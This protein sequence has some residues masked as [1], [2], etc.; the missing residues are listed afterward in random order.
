MLPVGA[1]VSG[2]AGA[3]GLGL[4][5][6]ASLGPEVGLGEGFAMAL[7]TTQGVALGLVGVFEQPANA[8]IVKT[9]ASN[10]RK[11][12]HIGPPPIFKVVTFALTRSAQ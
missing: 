2:G 12:I 7:A 5:M 6:S 11:P 4:G 9:P 8:I 10:R 3:A 1:N